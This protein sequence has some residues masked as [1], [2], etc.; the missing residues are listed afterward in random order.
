[1][2]SVTQSERLDLGPW[3]GFHIG[4][5]SSVFDWTIFITHRFDWLRA[6]T[7]RHQFENRSEWDLPRA[8]LMKIRVPKNSPKIIFTASFILK[9]SFYLFLVIKKLKFL[10]KFVKFW[11]YRKFFAWTQSSL[12]AQEFTCSETQAQRCLGPYEESQ[13]FLEAPD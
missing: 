9:Y 12:L 1:M 8:T 3:A 11:K 13:V 2:S 5:S 7:R 10:I 6:S 4:A